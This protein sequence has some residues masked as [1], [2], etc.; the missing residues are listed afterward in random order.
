MYPL[1]PCHDHISI[2][3][4]IDKFILIFLQGPNSLVN[5]TLVGDALAMDLFSIDPWTG[6]VSLKTSLV[7]TA[8]Q[9]Y[10]VSKS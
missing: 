2:Q 6:V 7:G 4:T 10:A 1:V 5:Y 8:S 9:T 3:V